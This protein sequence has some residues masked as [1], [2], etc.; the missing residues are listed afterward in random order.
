MLSLAREI[1]HDVARSFLPSKQ[2]FCS[3]AREHYEVY[4][5]TGIAAKNNL[6]GNTD[7]DELEYRSGSRFNNFDC[8]DTASILIYH[9]V[10]ISPVL[11]VT[12]APA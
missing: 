4:I 8:K 1:S 2:F 5:K 3:K 11:F 6:S 12:L 7:D 10:G 9:H